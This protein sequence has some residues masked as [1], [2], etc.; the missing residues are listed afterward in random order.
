MRL[1]GSGTREVVSCFLRSSQHRSLAGHVGDPYVGEA[2][3]EGLTQRLVVTLDARAV[4]LLQTSEVDHVA[5]HARRD[6]PHMHESDHGKLASP[7]DGQR[8]S[9]DGCQQL[10]AAALATVETLVGAVPHTLDGVGAI[11]F[12]QNLV[13]AD[14]E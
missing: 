6:P 8:D 13:K 11:W 10:V 2:V 7:A 1:R 5:A 4:E 14:L 3:T 12:T 9:T